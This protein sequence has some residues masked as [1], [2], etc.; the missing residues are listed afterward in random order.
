MPSMADVCK[1][2]LCPGTQKEDSTVEHKNVDHV[3]L[4]M[5]GMHEL[6]DSGDAA[7]AAYKGGLDALQANR[8]QSWTHTL[9]ALPPATPLDQHRPQ[10]WSNQAAAAEQL[11]R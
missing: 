9:R 3:R 8:L 4:F 2:Y 11:F 7:H 5:T 6:A 10:E 1:P